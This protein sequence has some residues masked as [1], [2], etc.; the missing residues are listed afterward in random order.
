LQPVVALFQV[1]RSVIRGGRFADKRGERRSYQFSETC[2]FACV[3]FEQITNK[4]ILQKNNKEKIMSAT[5]KTTPA[6]ERKR[7]Y[8]VED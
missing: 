1:F 6:R 2:L 5:A 8:T 3:F 4:L 7:G